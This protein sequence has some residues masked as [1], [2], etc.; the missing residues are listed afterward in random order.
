MLEQ[1]DQISFDRVAPK[2]KNVT[3]LIRKIAVFIKEIGIII[4]LNSGTRNLC[5][6]SGDV[7]T[8][9][10]IVRCLRSVLGR[11]LVGKYRTHK[12]LT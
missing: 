2:R 1:N 8:L 11:S 7:M 9:I 12:K 3:D 10:H 5:G 4:F 6:T